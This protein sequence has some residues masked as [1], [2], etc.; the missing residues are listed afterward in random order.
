MTRVIF[1]TSTNMGMHVQVQKELEAVVHRAADFLRQDRV[2]PVQT[3]HQLQ[4]LEEV[5]V[6]RRHQTTALQVHEYSAVNVAR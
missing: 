1:Q 2:R 5:G 3:V 4:V 6:R